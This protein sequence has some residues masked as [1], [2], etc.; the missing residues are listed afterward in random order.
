MPCYLHIDIIKKMN[1]ITKQ[2][3][4]LAQITLLALCITGCSKSPES[5]IERVLEDCA[6]NSEIVNDSNMSGFEA[7]RFLASEMQ[8]MDTRDCP[9]EFREV[10]QQHINAWRSAELPQIN[11]TYNELVTI[12][13]RYGARVPESIVQ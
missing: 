11:A 8:K 9:P 7:A 6:K 5:A 3:T 2:I 12:A 10:F 13:A 4:I 1:T